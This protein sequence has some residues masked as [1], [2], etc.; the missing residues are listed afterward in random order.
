MVTP[1]RGVSTR[2]TVEN[3]TSDPRPLVPA[4]LRQRLEADEGVL[5]LPARELPV[6]QPRDLILRGLL[7]AMPTRPDT[8]PKS[9]D[10]E[11]ASSTARDG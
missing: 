6:Q 7:A 5:P 9:N 8:T 10:C 2:L 3:W 4:C 1:L 11:A